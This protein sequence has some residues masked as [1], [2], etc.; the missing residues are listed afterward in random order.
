MSDKQKKFIENKSII[1]ANKII[2][3]L[4]SGINSLSEIAHYCK[5]SPPTV[6]RVLQQMVELDWA[7]QDAISHKYYLGSLFIDVSSDL[8]AAHRYLVVNALDEMNHLSTI[9]E[10]TVNLAILIQLHYVQLHSILGMHSLKISEASHSFMAPFTGATGKVLL[11]QLSNEEI[12]EVLQ[13]INLAQVTADNV[14]DETKLLAQLMEIKQQGY[15]VSCG[16]R[17]AGA[18]CISVPICNYTHPAA[19]SILGPTER[20]EP[21]LTELTEALKASAKRISKNI[22]GIFK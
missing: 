8:L 1:R 12:S 21:R 5:Y 19:L 22:S 17:I 11:S 14:T 10:E 2:S 9:S 7:T 16:E 13:K 20:L 3:C 18:T 15:T 4:R 6:H